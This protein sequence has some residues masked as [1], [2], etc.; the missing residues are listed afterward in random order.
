MQRMQKVTKKAAAA[1]TL[2]VYA[3]TLGGWPGPSWSAAAQSRKREDVKPRGGFQLLSPENGFRVTLPAGFDQP[4]REE[5]ADGVSYVGVSTLGGECVVNV[6]TV[7]RA[8]IGNATSDQLFDGLRN[9]VLQKYKGRIDQEENYVVQNHPARAVFFT[10]FVADDRTVF[11]RADFVYAKSRIF[12][13]I[14]IGATPNE[15]E[16]DDVQRFF[17]SFTLAESR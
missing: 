15:L 16:R 11:G 12:K 10:G 5:N 1:L 8:E 3:L 17:E 13:L 6:R 4:K 9:G 2:S 7:S 14:Y